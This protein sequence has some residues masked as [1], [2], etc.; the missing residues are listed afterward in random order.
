MALKDKFKEFQNLNVN[1]YIT[2][3][4]VKPEHDLQDYFE[5][6]SDEKVFSQ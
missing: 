5:I 4:Q 6:Y 3:R 1:D 2:L